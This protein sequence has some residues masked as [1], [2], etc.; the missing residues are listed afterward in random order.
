MLLLPDPQY[1]DCY[2]FDMRRSV[3]TKGLIDLKLLA[4]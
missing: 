4:V 2:F 3:A 1:D